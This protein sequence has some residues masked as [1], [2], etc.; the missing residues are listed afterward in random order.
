M[1]EYN[2]SIEELLKDFEELQIREI[3][4]QV[5]TNT[6]A[7][8]GSVGSNFVNPDDYEKGEPSHQSRGTCL[9]YTSPSPRD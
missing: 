6:G 7:P 3:V 4:K 2:N 5:N 9:L 8:I 1:D